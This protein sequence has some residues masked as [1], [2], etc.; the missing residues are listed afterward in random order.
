MIICKD[1]ALKD[2]TLIAEDAIAHVKACER[3][4][5]NQAELIAINEL[6]YDNPIIH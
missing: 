6:L 4:I 3:V 2:V 1:Q 5:A